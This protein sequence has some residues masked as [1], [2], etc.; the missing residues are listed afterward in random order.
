MIIHLSDN[1]FTGELPSSLGEID[2]LYLGVV[3]NHF[4]GPLPASFCDKGDWMNG[5]VGLVGSCDAIACPA[6]TF[7]DD[8]VGSSET[9]C[10]PCGSLETAPFLGSYSCSK[11]ALEITALKQ[12]YE[13]TAGSQWETSDNWM[14]YD[15]PICSWYGVTCDGGPDANST[16]TE[17]DLGE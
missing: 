16:I 14:E 13:A 11:T 1:A 17:I 6:G 4:E 7:N 15:K 12:L 2:T 10:S 3:G 9:S 5:E 8:G